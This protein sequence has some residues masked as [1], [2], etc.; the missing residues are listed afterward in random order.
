MFAGGE[1]AASGNATAEIRPTAIKAA[2]RFWWRALAWGRLGG[3]LERLKREEDAL[4][5]AAADTDSN[6]CGQAAFV[7]RLTSRPTEERHI[8][9]AGLFNFDGT[10]KELPGGIQYLAYGPVVRSKKE[11]EDKALVRIERSWV[12]PGATF[13]IAVRLRPGICIERRKK[14]KS[15]ASEA[16]KAGVVKELADAISAFGLLGGMGARSRR[17]FGSVRLLSLMIGDQEAFKAPAD[18]TAYIEAVQKLVGALPRR[19]SKDEPGWTAFSSG[20]PPQSNAGGAELRGTVCAI[21][22]P[23]DKKPSAINSEGLHPEPLKNKYRQSLDGPLDVLDMLGTGMM[24]YRG[25]GL[26]KLHGKPWGKI[27]A[28]N[29]P[30]WQQFPKD[31]GWF[32]KDMQVPTPRPKDHPARI[33]FGLPHNYH[34]QKPHIQDAGVDAGTTGQDRRASPLVLHVHK[35][36]D[37]SDTVYIGVA[38]IF[39]SRFHEHS[40]LDYMRG[41]TPNKKAVAQGTASVDYGVLFDMID[42]DGQ[43][44]RRQS[45]FEARMILNGWGT[46]VQPGE[47]GVHDG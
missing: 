7:F 16:E 30:A 24:L 36:G 26:S 43:N 10:N 2:L 33:A 40:R 15:E 42:G 3:D 29:L 17:G 6:D 35:L 21:L 23:G 12:K 5:G 8:S 13:G 19:P 14:N 11:G 41:R 46:G 28:H 47:E 39:P 34:S 18:V 37:G 9:H 27:S 25:W 44:G 38:T 4:F 1:K 20:S 32:E 22:G 45:P 31:H